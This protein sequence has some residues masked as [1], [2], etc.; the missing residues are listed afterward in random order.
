MNEGE[1]FRAFKNEVKLRWLN[2]FGP[3]QFGELACAVDLD[4]GTEDFDLVGIHSFTKMTD[5]NANATRETVGGVQVFAIRILAFSNR[6][7]QFTAIVL[8]RM[9]PTRP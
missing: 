3:L 7:G 4:P 5:V 9:N 8:S 6:L 1:I 2:S